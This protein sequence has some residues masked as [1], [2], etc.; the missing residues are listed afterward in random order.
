MYGDTDVIPTP[1]TH[2]VRPESPYGM[3]KLLIEQYL[4]F[5]KKTYGLDYVSLR[6]ANIYGPRQNSKGEAGVIAIFIDKLLANKRRL[7]SGSGW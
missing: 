5:Y 6:Y 2:P 3:A 7:P 1:E 4:E